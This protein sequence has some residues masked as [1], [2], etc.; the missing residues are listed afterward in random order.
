MKLLR[1][2]DQPTSDLPSAQESLSNRVNERASIDPDTQIECCNNPDVPVTQGHE[3]LIFPRCPVRD[4]P[5][6]ILVRSCCGGTGRQNP[7]APQDGEPCLIVPEI[8]CTTMSED[9]LQ[10][11]DVITSTGMDN[12]GKDRLQSEAISDGISSFLSRVNL[13]ELTCT[14]LEPSG[15][16]SKCCC[17]PESGTGSVIDNQALSSLDFCGCGGSGTPLCAIRL[18]SRSMVLQML[19]RPV[20]RIVSQMLVTMLTVVSATAVHAHCKIPSYI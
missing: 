12:F 8:L 17:G 9:E 10:D 20:F 3:T 13:P 11:I 2:H 16:N 15:S 1:D 18:T 19:Q 14:D 4:E 5:T 7:S 6:T